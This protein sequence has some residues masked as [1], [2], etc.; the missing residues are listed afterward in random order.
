MI[1]VVPTFYIVSLGDGFHPDFHQFLQHNAIQW[2]P[3]PDVSFQE[4]LYEFAGRLCYESWTLEDGS[5]VNKNLT[6]IRSGNQ[7]YLKNI[8]KSRHGSVLE[9]GGIVILYNNVSRVFTHELVRH[10]VGVAMSQTSGRYVR[11]DDIKFWIPPSLQPVD[12]ILEKTIHNIE[13]AVRVMSTILDVNNPSLNFNIKKKLTSA[14]RRIT[15][16][17]LAN[18]ILFSYNG[19]SLRHVMEMRCSEAAEEEMQFV[20][21]PLAVRLKSILP[22]LLQDLDLETFTFE[23][24]KV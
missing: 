19:R 9:H 6:K 4:S 21:R 7:E 17:G 22:S 23:N 3:D 12:Q 8:L 10:R 13:E 15:P 11:A 16:N 5:F 1:K 14:L 2:R 18:N 24:S 20:M